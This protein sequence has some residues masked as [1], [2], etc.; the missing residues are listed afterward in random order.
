[1]AVTTCWI[2]CEFLESFVT[3][4]FK[5]VG[6]DPVIQKELCAMRDDLRLP[7]TFPFE[8]KSSLGVSGS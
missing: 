4:A 2:L 3:D 6:V 7:Y 5:G 1:M 8:A